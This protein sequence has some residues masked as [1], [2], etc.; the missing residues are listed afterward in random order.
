MSAEHRQKQTPAVTI[1][2]AGRYETTGSWVT[3]YQRLVDEYCVSGQ[4]DSLVSNYHP[5]DGNPEV[6]IEERK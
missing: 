5:E 2:D 4:Q 6:A 1:K 3:D